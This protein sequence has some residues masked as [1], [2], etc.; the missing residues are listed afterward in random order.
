MKQVSPFLQYNHKE[1]PH[2][3]MVNPNLN[4]SIES[5]YKQPNLP[6]CVNKNSPQLCMEVEGC[7]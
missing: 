1:K 4:N 5:P 2:I 7:C 3:L 6:T